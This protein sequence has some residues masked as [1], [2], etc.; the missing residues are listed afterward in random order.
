MC[1]YSFKSLDHDV[2][3]TVD[4]SNLM[5]N[6]EVLSLKGASFLIDNSGNLVYS[7]SDVN[8]GVR[9]YSKI[10]NELKPL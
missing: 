9:D 3:Y 6:L 10:I 4:Q 2:M 8:F 7:F 5:R 1:T